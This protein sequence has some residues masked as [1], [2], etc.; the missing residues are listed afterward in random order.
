M[1]LADSIRLHI[2]RSELE[3]LCYL[4]MAADPTPIM[5]VEIND[6]I[7]DVLDRAAAEF[8]YTDWV[9]AYQAIPG[10]LP[11]RT[12]TFDLMAHL[13]RQRE[14]SL[15]TFGP[16]DRRKGIVDHLRKELQEIE[17]NPK[18]IFEWIDIVLLGLDGA[19]RAGHTPEQIV[20]ALAA[21]QTKNEGRVWPDWRTQDADKAIEHDRSGEPQGLPDIEPPATQ[22]EESETELLVFQGYSDDTFGEYGRRNVDFCDNGSGTAIEWLITSPDGEQ[23]LVIGQYGKG[24]ATGWV[25]GVAPWDPDGDDE[26]MPDWPI[27]IE[28]SERAYSPALFVSAPKGSTLR[29][30]QETE[31]DE[32]D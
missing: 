22:A 4:R 19:W 31:D 17:N 28:Q 32:Q 8:G 30:L 1:N 10:G 5:E 29:C 20:E 2:N 25:V 21:K 7:G 15:A 11:I 26:T 23:L 9:Q 27:S 6:Q 14:W 3:A 12:P 18:D 16:G 13:H 24:A